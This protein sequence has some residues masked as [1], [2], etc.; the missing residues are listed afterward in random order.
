MKRGMLAICA[1]FAA[2]APAWAGLLAY[3]EKKDPSYTWKQVASSEADADLQYAELQMVSQT[4]QGIEWKHRL[5]VARPA[6]MKNASQILLIIGG[7]SWNENT[8][9]ERINPDSRDLKLAMTIAR[10]TQMPVAFLRHVPF[11]PIFDGRKED[12]IIAYTFDK[13]LRTGD[14]EWPL[15]LPMT[16]AAVRAMDTI[17]AF[18]AKEWQLKVSKFVVT[19]ASKRGWTT[20]LTGVVDRRVTAIAPMVIDVLNMGSQMKRQREVYGGYSEEIEDYTSLKIQDRMDTDEGRK[21]LE[22]VDPYAYRDRLTMPKLILLGTNDPYWTVDALNLYFDG[23]KGEKYVLYIPNV[24]HGLN[25]MVRLISSVSAFS[26]K[27]AGKLEFPHP[28]WEFEKG[29]NAIR[30]RVRSDVQPDSVTIWKATSESQDFRKSRW[31]PQPIE[32]SDGAWAYTL[33]RPEKGYAAAFA[34]LRYTI[35][36]T[37]LYLSTT[38]RVIQSTPA[39]GKP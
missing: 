23:L 24:G 25:D 33:E 11:Q 21:L 2:S 16:K 10:T 14:E 6:G 26:L 30:L 39:E 29:D 18:A 27:A 38:M 37:P 34:E 19:G 32:A 31:M 9:N 5:I 3:V 8:E 35:G 22:I 4:W 1:V 28:A 7:G 20:W 12:Q 15:L 17:Q 36:Q 13:Y